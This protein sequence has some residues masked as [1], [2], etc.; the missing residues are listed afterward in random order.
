MSKDVYRLPFAS[1]GNSHDFEE[2][3]TSTKEWQKMTRDMQFEVADPTDPNREKPLLD[4]E[5]GAQVYDTQDFEKDYRTLTHQGR[6]RICNDYFYPAGASFKSLLDPQTQLRSEKGDRRLYTPDDKTAGEKMVVARWLP[7]PHEYRFVEP[8]KIEC[9]LAES[10]DGAFEEISPS[11]IGAGAHAALVTYFKSLG[12]S[13]DLSGSGIQKTNSGFLVNDSTDVKPDAEGFLRKTL[14]EAKGKATVGFIFNESVLDPIENGSLQECF[15]AL[16]RYGYLKDASKV[17]I[18]VLKVTFPIEAAKGFLDQLFGQ[19]QLTRYNS[20]QEEFG[21]DYQGQI[22]GSVQYYVFEGDPA[23]R[24]DDVIESMAVY[25][26]REN[27]FSVPVE[28][29]YDYATAAAAKDMTF[30]K[31]EDEYKANTLYLPVLYNI[32]SKR[33]EV[34]TGPLYPDGSGAVDPTWFQNNTAVTGGFKLPPGYRLPTEEELV[35]FR[36][37]S[38]GHAIRTPEGT[39]YADGGISIVNDENMFVLNSTANGNTLPL[40]AVAQFYQSVTETQLATDKEFYANYNNV[41][42]TF[43]EI[44]LTYDQASA[45]SDLVAAT[46]TEFGVDIN[47]RRRSDLG[48]KYEYFGFDEPIGNISDIPSPIGFPF[49]DANFPGGTADGVAE[50]TGTERRKVAS[51][52]IKYNPGLFVGAIARIQ[53]ILDETSGDT[54]EIDDFTMTR[55]QAEELIDALEGAERGVWEQLNKWG[56]KNADLLLGGAVSALMS[57]IAFALVLV[58]G[59][60]LLIKYSSR[61]RELIKTEYRVLGQAQAEGIQDRH[62]D[63][64]AQKKTIDQFAPSLLEERQGIDRHEKIGR[65]PEIK[66]VL[67]YFADKKRGKIK[68]QFGLLHGEGGT[69][70]SDLFIGIAD[71]LRLGSY[72]DGTP[73]ETWIRDLFKDVRVFNVKDAIAGASYQNEA[74]GY[75]QQV[76]AYQKAHPNCLVILDEVKDIATAGSTPTDPT[77]Y[78]NRLFKTVEFQSIMFTLATEDVPDFLIS[79]N[80]NPGQWKRRLNP[81]L[82]GGWGKGMEDLEPHYVV[83]I[84]KGMVRNTMADYSEDSNVDLSSF[85]EDLYRAIVRNAQARYDYGDPSRSINEFSAYMQKLI[86]D[87]EGQPTKLKPTLAHY[88]EFVRNSPTGDEAL[89]AAKNKPPMPDSAF[90]NPRAASTSTV[91]ASSSR[92]PVAPLPDPTAPATPGGPVVTPLGSSPPPSPVPTPDPTATSDPTGAPPAVAPPVV[93]APSVAPPSPPPPTPA[94]IAD[95]MLRVQLTAV[96]IEHGDYADELNR[97]AYVGGDGY[98]AR[99][100]LIETATAKIAALNKTDSTT[101][102]KARGILMRAMFDASQTIAGFDIN[103]CPKLK[104]YEQQQWKALAEATNKDLIEQLKTY[105]TLENQKS[106]PATLEKLSAQRAQILIYVKAHPYDSNFCNI[107]DALATQISIY[108][109]TNYPGLPETKKQELQMAMILQTVKQTTQA[110]KGKVDTKSVAFQ[111]TLNATY[112]K[113]LAGHTA[114]WNAYKSPAVATVDNTGFATGLANNFNTL[115]NSGATRSRH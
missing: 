28:K 52:A 29:T 2:G 30:G 47:M 83:D 73:V 106:P 26:G 62:G 44:W 37:S 77:S 14:E 11:Q 50:L 1:P 6:I 39:R 108:A 21:R 109:D 88:Q 74:E 25:R 78:L 57:G 92:S 42:G 107:F 9:R 100:R 87:A 85:T 93:A 3:T 60:A 72:P 64:N 34:V 113:T 13:D 56:K 114:T 75:I 17:D 99:L 59:K 31:V 95:G 22:L 110:L 82:Q 71:S 48:F 102:E 63:K 90:V 27:A 111:A 80:K 54:V 84:L 46:Q 79:L 76:L 97:T 94:Q 45:L 96:G 51:Y 24:F 43:S 103:T 19:S 65:T 15:L 5:T 91:T 98:S 49:F 55:D 105:A 33:V 12:K 89:V 20:S 104:A 40:L 38:G 69:G 23:N 18:T 4:P 35:G 8:N 58:L 70:K 112:A 36:E 67:R 66:K 101:T 115:I 10:S 86:Q 53:K 41:D 16:V 61:F 81:I 68:E 32:T 7:D